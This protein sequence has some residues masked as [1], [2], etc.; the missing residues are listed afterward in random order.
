MYRHPAA[1]DVQRAVDAVTLVDPRVHDAFYSNFATTRIIDR[2]GEIDVPVLVVSG[3]QDNVVPPTD[4]Y[5]TAIGMRLAKEVTLPN[6]GHMLPIE[7]ADA[8]AAEILT[9]ASTLAKES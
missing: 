4:Q 6:Q 2:L 3:A 9:F 7:A 5:R 8:A 1:G